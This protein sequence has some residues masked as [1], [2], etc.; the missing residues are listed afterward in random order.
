MTPGLDNLHLIAGGS[1]PPN[2]AELLDS[3]RLREFME[4]AK[5]EYRS[6]SVRLS[7]DSV[8]G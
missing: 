4:E 5:N 1:I 8:S 3:K 7:T 2:P 6:H